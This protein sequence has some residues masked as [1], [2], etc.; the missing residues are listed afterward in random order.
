M[1]K[2]LV[3]AFVSFSLIY[4]CN[5]Y[6]NNDKSINVNSSEKGNIVVN[7]RASDESFKIKSINFND[8]N[9]KKMK[10]VVKGNNISQTISQTL[11]YIP[12]QSLSFNLSVPMGKNKIVYLYGLDSSDKEVFSL[13]GLANVEP[14]KNTPAKIN[15]FE[16]SVAKVFENLLTQSPNLLDTIDSQNV[17]DF[18]KKVSDFDENF[19]SYKKI[20][21]LQVNSDYIA[22]FIKNNNGTLPNQDSEE[23][24]KKITDHVLII[25]IDGL[26]PNVLLNTN[27]PNLNSLWKQ[28]AYSFTAQTIFP[29]YTL[30][31]HTSMLTGLKPEKHN[32][33][34]NDFQPDKSITSKTVFHFAKEKGLKT[35]AFAG[36]DKFRHFETFVD[37]FIYEPRGYAHI[38]NG[39]ET[40]IINEKPNLSFVHLPEIDTTG[41]S[42]KWESLEQKTM[43]EQ[44]DLPIGE[45]IQR[46]NN[47]IP[48]MV[49]ILTSDHGGH[50]FTHGSDLSS[51][52]T[53]P[54][55]VKGKMIKSNYKVN[56]NVTTFD[57]A[58][59]ALSLLGIY[60]PSEMDGKPVSDIIDF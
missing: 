60:K 15:F 43:L 51:D 34:W 22:N 21:P 6:S 10:V 24:M 47:K 23:L 49:T 27:T 32:V 37:K 42:K 58:A 41:H 25:S 11:D 9:I 19:N 33:Y 39:S 54:W 16:T 1:M 26:M 29:S 53:I 20:H 18:I 14:N 46:I 12:N 48:D 36:K 55:I 50:D 57:T 28:G 7:L 59:T 52:M 44:I 38:L 8:P 35:S 31:S 2:K 30:P 4:S 45:F 13:M 40:Y 5:Y 3:L 56:F 17:R